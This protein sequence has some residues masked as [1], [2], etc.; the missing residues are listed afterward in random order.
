MSVSFSQHEYFAMKIIITDG[1]VTL[2]DLS[3]A[4]FVFVLPTIV[5]HKNNLFFLSNY[6]LSN[7]EL[8]WAIREKRKKKLFANR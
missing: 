3:F 4:M 7:T 1:V 2:Y 6:H 8:I 5:A